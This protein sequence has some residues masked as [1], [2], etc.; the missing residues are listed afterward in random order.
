[1][2]LL[3]FIEIKMPK[4][5]NTI[6]RMHDRLID[7]QN[8]LT[9]IDRFVEETLS[10][11]ERKLLELDQMID[12]ANNLQKIDPQ[13]HQTVKTTIKDIDKIRQQISQHLDQEVNFV[14]NIVDKA[15]NP[16]RKFLKL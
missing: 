8:N 10:E 14:Y 16:L 12:D 2:T 11:M 7:A 13:F 3:F 1:M 4:K 5:H 6:N 9:S 15:I